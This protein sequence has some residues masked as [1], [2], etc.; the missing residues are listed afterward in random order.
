MKATIVFFDPRYGDSR[1]FAD[2]FVALGAEPVSTEVDLVHLWSTR[3][4][5]AKSFRF[6]GMT[7]HSDRLIIER[8]AHDVRL[9]MR[10]EIFHDCR[11]ATT[12]THMLQQCGEDLALALDAAAATDW[13]AMVAQSFAYP[14]TATVRSPTRLATRTVRA[15]DHPGTLVSWLIA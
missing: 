12:V 13:P 14:T 8:C 10:A 3:F 6:A 15:P 11:G 5:S 7:P 4:A 1:R 9:R 2:A